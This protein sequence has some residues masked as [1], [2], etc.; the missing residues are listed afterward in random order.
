[1]NHVMRS[2]WQHANK[3]PEHPLFECSGLPVLPVVLCV[4]DAFPI[5]A[6][7]ISVNIFLSSHHPSCT[8]PVICFFAGHHPGFRR[9]PIPG[10][11]ALGIFR[12]PFLFAHLV[13]R[14]KFVCHFQF[15]LK[16]QPSDHRDPSAALFRSNG[17][18]RNTSFRIPSR[19]PCVP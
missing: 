9:H 19:L 10:S 17:I 8:F 18:R 5:G 14:H 2:G 11:T 15:L 3:K 7:L 6:I 4:K 1:M 16:K 12:P 13:F